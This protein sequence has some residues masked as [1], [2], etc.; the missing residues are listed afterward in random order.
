MVA[1]MRTMINRTTAVGTTINSKS[2][3]NIVSAS[4]QT[5]VLVG[6]ESVVNP[7]LVEA[8]ECVVVVSKGRVV[9]DTPAWAVREYTCIVLSLLFVSQIVAACPS[10]AVQLCLVLVIRYVR[11]SIRHS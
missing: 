1:T 3:L 2:F 8:E 7:P 9:S 4:G 11:N 5:G 10:S 6:V